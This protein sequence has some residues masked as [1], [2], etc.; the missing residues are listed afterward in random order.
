MTDELPPSPH[1]ETR[2]PPADPALDH[3]P[4]QTRLAFPN[5]LGMAKNLRHE[6][7]DALMEI[8]TPKKGQAAAYTLCDVLLTYV[9]ATNNST[10]L[11]TAGIASLLGS[12]NNALSV[13]GNVPRL[14]QAYGILHAREMIDFLKRRRRSD[15]ISYPAFLSEEAFDAV[16]KKAKPPASPDIGEG[17]S[18]SYK[19]TLYCYA[20]AGVCFVVAGA[21]G[22]G[23]EQLLS[24]MKGDGQ[25]TATE[26]AI[27]GAVNTASIGYGVLFAVGNAMNLAHTTYLTKM[28]IRNAFK[29][30]KTEKGWSAKW[31][32][33]CAHARIEHASSDTLLAA[34]TNWLIAGGA[35]LAG[36]IAYQSP[37]MMKAGGLLIAAATVSYVGDYCV[38]LDENQSLRTTFKRKS[39]QAFKSKSRMR[40]HYMLSPRVRRIVKLVRKAHPKKPAL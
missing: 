36:G 16:L 15:D 13:G 10:I 12:L 5:D 26:K 40:L 19:R 28:S 27:T 34:S 9:G 33:F 31:Q 1:E 25:I 21:T 35:L 29:H 7:N 30:A 8:L 20:A 22:T 23:F 39:V 14:V 17:H 32:K 38:R 3:V 11:V 18:D 2:S 37:M 4:E 24:F 6:F